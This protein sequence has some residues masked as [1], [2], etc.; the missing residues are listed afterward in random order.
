MA[1]LM[2]LMC[3]GLVRQHPPIALAP[4]LIHFGTNSDISGMGLKSTHL[5]VKIDT[6]HTVHNM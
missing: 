6:R 4:A 1:A 5:W 3:C 2:L